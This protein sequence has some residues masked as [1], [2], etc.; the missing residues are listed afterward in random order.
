MKALTLR[1]IKQML[2]DKRSLAMVLLAPMFIM[3]F[4]FLVLGDSTYTPKVTYND[5]PSALVEKLQQEDIVIIEP[6][7]DTESQ[8][9]DGTVDAVI[10]YDN[11]V[12]NIRLLEPNSVIISKVTTALSNINAEQGNNAMELSFIY[13]D[14]NTSTFEG[15]VHVLLGIFSFF[16]VFLISGIAFVREKTNGTIERLMLTPISRS[17]VVAGTILGYGIFAFIQ[18]ILLIAFVSL[19]LGITI[20]GSVVAIVITMT[21]LSFLAI[22]LGSLV[23]GLAKNEYQVIQFIP[24]ILTPQIFFSGLIPIATLPYNLDIVAMFMPLQYAVSALNI[25][26]N[27]SG[28]M[29][30]ILFELLVL[31]GFIVVLFIANVFSLKKY[32]IV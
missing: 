5:L 25:I 24:L 16:L 13:G 29:S 31:C 23:S 28:G 22:A 6:D 17:S 4:M 11:N 21:L 30:N 32:R 1:I 12:L 19:F 9:L 15:M 20:N 10:Y 18:S 14:L 8:L 27:H 2:N 3:T 7:K 26:I